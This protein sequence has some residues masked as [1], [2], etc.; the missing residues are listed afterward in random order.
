MTSLRSLDSLSDQL[1]QASIPLASEGDTHVPRFIQR[2]V[3]FLEKAKWF[4]I[5][6][7]VLAVGGCVYPALQVFPATRIFFDPPEGSDTYIAN[8]ILSKYFPQ[9]VK[10]AVSV[11]LINT[12]AEPIAE[13]EYVRGIVEDVYDSL[14]KKGYGEDYVTG[15][16]DYF[17]LNDAGLTGLANATI[18]V[19]GPSQAMIV[20]IHIAEMYSTRASAFTTD[21]MDIVDDWNKK[22]KPG[23]SL[24]RTGSKVLFEDFVAYLLEELITTDSITAT[25]ALIVIVLFVGSVPLIL[26]P[27][28]N[29]V[30][31]IVVSM[32]V[33]YGLAQV[34]MVASF[35][36][37]ILLSLTLAIT[38]D[39][40]FFLL[41]RYNREIAEA[42][43]EQRRAVLRTVGFAGQVIS[44]SGMTLA[45][46]FLGL[47]LLGVGFMN[48]VG[49]GCF[50]A[51]LI[52]I[53]SN[54]S[55][56]PSLLLAF[57]N[58]FGRR[59]C[60]RCKTGAMEDSIWFKLAHFGTTTKGA[61]ILLL[62][63]IAVT[64]PVIIGVKWFKE[65]D[66]M[67]LIFIS[68]LDSVEA[69]SAIQNYF[70][71]GSIFPIYAT[72]ETKDWTGIFSPE[73][74]NESQDFIRKIISDTNQG[75]AGDSIL[76]LSW[77]FGSPI[78]FGFAE[79]L[80]QINPNYKYLESQLKNARGDNNSQAATMSLFTTF[81]PT[82]ARFGEFCTQLLKSSKDFAE[83]HTENFN[84][85]VTGIQ[86]GVRALSDRAYD[87]FPMMLGITLAVAAVFIGGT[88]RSVVLPIRLV[89]TV[90]WTVA[91]TYGLESFVFCKGVSSDGIY[92]VVPL[93]LTTI[94]VGLG[95]DYDI[96]LFT[97]VSE[98]R[99]EGKTP[100]RAIA[101]GYYHTGEVITGAGLVMAIAFSGLALSGMPTLRQM[102]VF[103]A[104]S[105]LL[106]TFIVRMLMVPP[107][108]H[109]LGRF[110][111]WPNKYSRRDFH[112][113]TSYS[114]IH[115]PLA[116]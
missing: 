86:L 48:G 27:L 25:F 88:L 31:S 32:A 42:P 113:D 38:I 105:V 73:Y 52:M 4:V 1:P 102:G 13:S 116:S 97:R 87:R 98:L 23:Y 85:T 7:W 33:L 37:G 79:K 20:T 112:E 5:L 76:A 106:D 108:L 21:L 78:E 45:I 30:T 28:A 41:V 29:L 71:P 24:Y 50:V 51:L 69:L 26:L 84:W 90:G 57:P 59:L 44:V 99:A 35:V 64:V 39:Y 107:L 19:S 77:P 96:F 111:W 92:W 54:L 75:I 109:F 83:S 74:F 95:C 9:Y 81:S 68:A 55:L 94:V 34:W 12:T 15:K 60:W 46:S 10:E 67:S 8:Q 18:N 115:A 72:A 58:F 49:V 80:D 61:I 43:T 110:N 6:F 36:P 104:G 103:L 82:T 114:L 56:G 62:V 91:W 100:D 70:P 16:V 65:V 3:A 63:T 17:T 89:V 22:L 14:G 53:S 66:D 93:M 47:V 40:S 11:L 2:Y 101:E